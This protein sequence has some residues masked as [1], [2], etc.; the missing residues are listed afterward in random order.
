M[1]NP[2]DL[3]E[4]PAPRPGLLFEPF[5]LAGLRLRNRIVRSA[6][7]EKRA[8]EDGFVTEELTALYEAL[9][10]GGSGLIITGNALVHPS[11]RAMPNMLSIHNDFY[12]PGLAELASAVHRKGGLIAIQLNHGGR[13]CPALLL[14]GE[15]PLAPSEV[16]DPS[17]GVTP[18]A[19]ADAEIWD[20]V[21]AFADAADRA[22]RAGFDAV[23][24]H[25]AHGFLMSSFLSPHTN[26]RD[27]Y[28]GGDEERRFHFAE[29]VLKAVRGAVGDFPVLIKMNCDD[30]LPGGIEP[31]E[32]AR[33]ARRLEASGLD[34][35]EISG[36]MRES[37]VRAARPD[38]R[39]PEDE[40]YF[41]DSGR[42]F[43]ESLRIPVILTGGMRTRAVM[44]KMLA[45]GYADLVGMSRPLI[46]QPDLPN[47]MKAEAEKAD[48]VSCNGCLD[49]GR[50]GPVGCARLRDG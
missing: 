30:L 15:R 23:Q 3:P 4:P 29:E 50:P 41:R 49:F 22:R 34:A 44:E 16:P 28:W 14:G 31:A 25:A 36:G 33:A 12:V 19:M 46:R 20:M 47:R 7:Y 35:V 6:T 8:D 38:V 40:A 11:G 48:C 37:R 27:D 5:S 45:G 21:D 17:S 1:S 43:K 2:V 26:R 10:A 32:S 13:Q 18:R 39:G 24:L 42:L 9:A